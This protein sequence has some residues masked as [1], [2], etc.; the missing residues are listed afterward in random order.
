MQQ[1]QFV[2]GVVIA[3]A[4]VGFFLPVIVA[5]IRGTDPMWPVVLLTLATGFTGVTWFAAWI[6]VFAFPRR[7]SA[8]PRR[9]AHPRQPA[10]PPQD[11]PRCLYG[12]V[13]PAD[14]AGCQPPA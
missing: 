12:G 9:S 13:P 10:L 8:P 4:I 14:T 6:A 7:R 1:Q 3:G 2:W 5:A 11:D